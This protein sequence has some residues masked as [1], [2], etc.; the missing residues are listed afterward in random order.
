MSS[1]RFAAYLERNAQ[2]AATG[3]KEHVPAIPFIPF[4]QLYV[5]TC[6][7]PRK[8]DRSY[9]G[10]RFDSELLRDLPEGIDP[11][12]ENGEF[13]TFVYAGPVFSSPIACQVGATVERDGFVFCDVLS[14]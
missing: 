13:H 3:A 10:R 14:A 12:G 7:D 5:I 9:C 2:F 8:L 4:N 1:S 11:C 6:I